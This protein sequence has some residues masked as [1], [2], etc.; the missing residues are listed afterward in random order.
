MF[1][2]YANKRVAKSLNYGRLLYIGGSYWYLLASQYQ[3]VYHHVVMIKVVVFYF[4]S[5]YIIGE[6]KDA[7]KKD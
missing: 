6:V 5:M 4:F 3:Y 7:P 2:Q 1:Y